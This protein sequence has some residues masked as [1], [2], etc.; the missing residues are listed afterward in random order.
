MGVNT[1]KSVSIVDIANEFVT[2]SVSKVLNENSTTA[3]VSQTISI[4]CSD[5]V[6]AKLA[7]VCGKAKAAYAAAVG[8]ELAATYEYPPSCNACSA[9]NIEQDS[10]VS[11]NTQMINNNKIAN[12]IKSDIVSKIENVLENKQSGVV[13]V[14][15]QTRKSLETI[16]TKFVTSFNTEVVNKNLS[17]VSLNQSITASN[18]SIMNVKQNMAANF[19]AK[20]IVDSIITSDADIKAELD[21]IQKEIVS[22]SGVADNVQ[23]TIT[24][25][26]DGIFSPSGIIL[27]LGAIAFILIGALMYFKFMK[28]S[29]PFGSQQPF[30]SPMGY[31]FG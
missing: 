22:T 24:G 5:D 26:V 31:S 29:S 4:S 14:S 6:A 9:S 7:E 28:Q 20:N 23:G 15:A 19:V 12:D 16:K 30:N 8:S 2:E 10:T 17:V 1:S 21:N 18:S 13:G 25:V 27:I 11:I 3:S